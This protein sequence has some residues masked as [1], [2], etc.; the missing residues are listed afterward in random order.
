M[1][2]YLFIVLFVGVGFGQEILESDVHG[3][4]YDKSKLHYTS[5]EKKINGVIHTR[6]KCASLK[7]THIFWIATAWNSPCE[8]EKYLELLSEIRKNKRGG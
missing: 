6:Y 7:Q 5:K 4:P 2:K 1:K 8:N 3:C